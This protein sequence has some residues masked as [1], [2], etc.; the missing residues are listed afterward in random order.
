MPS[1]AGTSNAWLRLFN[2]RN[3][4]VGRIVE[5]VAVG[6]GLNVSDALIRAA[7]HAG[8][9]R[10]IKREIDTRPSFQKSNHVDNGQSE[11]RC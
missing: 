9:A 1:G 11:A 7:T 4:G 2:G 8:T 6:D 3:A 10:R 5:R